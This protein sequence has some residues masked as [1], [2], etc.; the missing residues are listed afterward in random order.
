MSSRSLQ[1]KKLNEIEQ[2]LRRCALPNM[3]KRAD[4]EAELLQVERDLKDL[5]VDYEQYFM[6]VTKFEPAKE[7]SIL[8]LR[9]RRLTNV[10]IPQTDLRFRLH[11][12]LSRMQSFSAYWDRILR[13]IEEG[14]YERQRSHIKWAEQ[15]RP[16][17]TNGTAP[18]APPTTTAAD[19]LDR[20]YRD[21]VRAHQDCQMPAPPRE[22]VEAFLKR[23][24]DSIREKFGDRTFDMVVAV[25]NGKPKIKVRAKEQG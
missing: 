7:R 20:V 3:V 11:G 23:Q 18:V 17:A 13:L 4:V 8:T 22:Q 6:G 15:N 19:P 10:Y 16:K 5:E 2:N 9:L 1:L 14:R 12:L 25:E 24:A 21:L